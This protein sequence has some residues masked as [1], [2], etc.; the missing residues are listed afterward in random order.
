MKRGLKYFFFMVVVFGCK[1]T[2]TLTS[3][4]LLNPKLNAKQILKIHYNQKTEFSTLQARLKLELIEGEKAQSHTVSLRMKQDEV[5][6]INAFLN[7]VRIKITPEKVWMYNK[8]NKTYFEGDFSLIK[9]FLGINMNF[10]HLQNLILAEVIFPHKPNTLTTQYHAKSYA[11]LPKIQHSLFDILYFINPKYFKMDGFELSQPLELTSLKIQYQSFQVVDQQIFP[12][13]ITINIVD[14]QK[15]MTL[16]MNLKSIS[17]NQ[18][19][20]F[21]FKLPSGYKPIEF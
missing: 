4:E 13:D 2:K 21:P 15:Q 14:S 10:I 12:Q 17:L 8:L 20:Q 19:L 18:P 11:L 1:S 6:W 5:I 9:K 7:M 16:A 3:D